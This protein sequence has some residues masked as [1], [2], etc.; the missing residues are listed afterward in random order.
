M[1]QESVVPTGRS[2]RVRMEPGPRVLVVD[3]DE[4]AATELARELRR[5]G[6]EVGRSRGGEDALSTHHNAELVLLKWG[7]AD[8]DS[9]HV[10]RYLRASST[11]GIIALGGEC[12]ETDRVRSLDAGS[13]DHIVTSCGLHE[14]IARMTAVLRRVTVADGRPLIEIG[15]LTVDGEART[16]DLRGEPIELA[17]KEFDLLWI[18]AARAGAVVTRRELMAEVWGDLSPVATRTI[19]THVSTL[20][21][22][23]GPDVPI[24]TVRGVGF[25][26]PRV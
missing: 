22:K 19:D 21:G 13:D 25:Q 15:P 7:L 23:L 11:V 26:I 6:Y 20:R 16:V 12:S 8:V 2:D 9:A 3:D 1:S 18:L 10:C 5:H 17:R 4:T 24:T 14:L